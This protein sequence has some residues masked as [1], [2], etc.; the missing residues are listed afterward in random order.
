MKW[1]KITGA[2]GYKV[3]RQAGSSTKWSTVATIKSGSTVSWTDTKTSSG[4]K[5]TYS[6]RAYSGK[7]MSVQ[8]STNGLTKTMYRLSRPSITYLKNTGSRKFTVKWK[9]VSGATGYQVSRR[10]GSA[11]STRVT[12]K[13]GSTVSKSITGLS[14]G[15]T[16][17]VYVRAYKTVGGKNYYSAWSGAKSVIISK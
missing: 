9:K 8:G 6:V 15:K 11:A 2:S 10:I 1:S 7:Y 12:V 14:K 17:K 13:G 5:Y 3:Y 16:Y 4:T